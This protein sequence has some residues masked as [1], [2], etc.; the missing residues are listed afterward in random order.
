M[1]D[2]I[3]DFL[4]LN[5]K[6]IHKNPRIWVNYTSY[7]EEPDYPTEPMLNLTK[8]HSGKGL[9]H[10]KIYYFGLEQSMKIELRLM[11][12]YEWEPFFEGYIS[13]LWDLKFI[14]NCIGIPY[15]V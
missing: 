13:S 12:C 7:D 8:S 10:V 14:M 15:N 9:A 3:I 4:N 2:P 11:S 5:F 1:N 6:Q